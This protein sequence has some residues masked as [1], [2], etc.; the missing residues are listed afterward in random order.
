LLLVQIY[1]S[2]PGLC[3]QPSDLVMSRCALQTPR[4]TGSAVMKQVVTNI[5]FELFNEEA[6]RRR[7]LRR[8]RR[9]SDG[10]RA[11]R[12]VACLTSW[13]L[14]SRFRH[15][16]SAAIAG[17]T[18]DRAWRFSRIQCSGHPACAWS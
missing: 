10:A 2:G 13:P 1:S 4:A 12:T 3:M 17:S 9:R 11:H 15:Y 18:G 5:C 8:A 14:S 6:S 16:V 7:K